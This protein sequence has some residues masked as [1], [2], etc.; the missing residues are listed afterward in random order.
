[1]PGKVN[2]F[3]LAE[4]E[5]G[6]SELVV[7]SDVQVLARVKERLKLNWLN[8]EKLAATGSVT[9]KVKLLIVRLGGFN[10]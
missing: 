4:P 6:L 1:M 9:F 8:P 2:R 10:P 5:T 7:D 3:V